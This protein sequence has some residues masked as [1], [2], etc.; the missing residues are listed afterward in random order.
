MNN[1]KSADI[2]C[3]KSAASLAFFIKRAAFCKVNT[4]LFALVNK[5]LKVVSFSAIGGAVQGAIRLRLQF[6]KHLCKSVFSFGCQKWKFL[7]IPAGVYKVYK[8][9]CDFSVGKV[10]CN[11]RRDFFDILQH[12]KFLNRTIFSV[13]SG[14]F[15][16]ITRV[17]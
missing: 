4:A 16:S 3:A 11:D 1:Q 5:L 14:S 17:A 6:Q 15:A 7:S 13:L 2:C 10:V 12:I 9:L 8:V